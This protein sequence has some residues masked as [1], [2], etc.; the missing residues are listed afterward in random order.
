MT[1]SPKVV[2]VVDVVVVVASVVVSVVVVS[3]TV[4][5][6]ASVV[7][8]SVV[9]DVVVVSGTVVVVALVVVTSVVVDVVVVS[10]TVVVVASVVV[11]VVVVSGTVVVVASVV[12]AVV[13]V[14]VVV[15]S[16]TVVVVAS[17]VV[18]GE[19]TREQPAVLLTSST[20]LSLHA[21]PLSWTATQKKAPPLQAYSPLLTVFRSV[22]IC[23]AWS[24]LAFEP[25][26]EQSEIQWPN[27][28]LFGS[29]SNISFARLPNMLAALYCPTPDPSTPSALIGLVTPL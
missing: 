9:V 28:T 21:P 18:D 29:E 2:V 20:T 24:A 22:V 25:V 7:V 15:V 1:G 26:P 19:L 13:V 8:T 10:G 14:A 16:G 11:A 27:T 4:V 5:V 3:G 23:N 17:V 6:V 12:V